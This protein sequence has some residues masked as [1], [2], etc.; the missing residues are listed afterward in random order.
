MTSFDVFDTSPLLVAGLALGLGIGAQGFINQMLDGDEGL[1][2]F[3]RDGSGYNKSGFRPK[4]NQP[5]TKSDD[6]LPW[7]KLPQLDFVEVA[8]Q[9]SRRE[10]EALM[11]KLESMRTEMN[12][13][14][15]QGKVEEAR[16]IQ[17][18][19]EVWMEESGIQFTADR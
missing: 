17:E 14:L 2:A 9:P 6:P 3:L 5:S 4:N 13:L 7:L 15:D 18:D 19:L 12:N 1:G 8:G 16:L 10:E 11:K